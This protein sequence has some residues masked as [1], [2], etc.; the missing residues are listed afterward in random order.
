MRIAR[1]YAWK[2]LSAQVGRHEKPARTQCLTSAAHRLCPHPNSLSLLSPIPKLA[3]ADRSPAAR[4]PPCHPSTQAAC[5]VD[6][7][8]LIRRTAPAI[9]SLWLYPRLTNTRVPLR[10]SQDAPPSSRSIPQENRREP[11][12][13]ATFIVA[14][15]GRAC[16]FPSYLISMVAMPSNFFLIASASSLVALSLIALGAPSTRS[17]AS[18]R[19]SEVTSRTA[20]MVLILFA[21]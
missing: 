5:P 3:S 17:L 19:P 2:A 18:F 9:R 13:R 4:Q 16:K 6:S 15:P 12:R 14:R 21:P 10:L 20:L 11:E 8:A 7:T 1:I